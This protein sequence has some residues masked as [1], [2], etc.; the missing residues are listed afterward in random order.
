M[1][2]LHRPVM[3]ALTADLQRR[4]SER[5]CDTFA[6][7]LRLFFEFAAKRLKSDP[8]GQIF[9]DRAPPVRRR[10]FV[11]HADS[12]PGLANRRSRRLRR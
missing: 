3:Q 7:A 11:A 6:L 12:Q 2:D 8:F 1:L 10:S 9:S 5:A 4:T